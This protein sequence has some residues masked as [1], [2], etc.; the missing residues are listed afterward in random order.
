MKK[1][2]ET[3]QDRIKRCNERGC[4]TRFALF[5]APV[6]TPTPNMGEEAFESPLLYQKMTP[7]S[8]PPHTYL[9]GV[10]RE[11]RS[12]FI[13]AVCSVSGKVERGCTAVSESSSP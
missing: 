13:C 9:R 3:K 10:Y 12:K 8:H 2:N 7:D 1:N 4:V 5:S 11:L 6:L